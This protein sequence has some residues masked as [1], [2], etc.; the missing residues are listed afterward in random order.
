MDK[1]P[2]FDFGTLYLI[3]ECLT[4]YTRG[5][6]GFHGADQSINLYNPPHK[7]G[8]GVQEAERGTAGQQTNRAGAEEPYLQPDQQREKSQTWGDPAQAVQRAAPKQVSGREKD[9]GLAPPSGGSMHC[10]GGWTI[11]TVHT[12]QLKISHYFNKTSEMR[13]TN[14]ASVWDI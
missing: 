7:A 1:C 5:R 13:N 2:Y 3:F 10:I 11:Y 8:A 4:L 9:W 6:Q 14:K 12:I